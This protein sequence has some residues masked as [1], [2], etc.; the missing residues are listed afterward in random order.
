ADGR[1]ASDIVFEQPVELRPKS[2][3]LASR[4]VDAGKLL[5]RMHERL[6][7]VAATVGAEATRLSYGHGFLL[8]RFTP[9]SALTACSGSLCR[10]TLVPTSTKSAPAAATRS[11]SARFSIPLS[12]T[13]ATLLG[14]S[15]I[16][17]SARRTSIANVARSRAFT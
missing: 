12:A 8:C 4:L 15:R 14:T 13:T 3:I 5:E 7:D 11:T 6:G 2:R 16:T 10:A 9:V 17:A 1:R